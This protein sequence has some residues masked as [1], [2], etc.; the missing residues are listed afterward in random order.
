MRGLISLTS[1]DEMQKEID[2]LKH[3]LSK[4]E[5]HHKQANNLENNM[6][7]LSDFCQLLM[8]DIDVLTKRIKKLGE[9]NSVPARL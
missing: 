1:M 3:R 6:I 5:E 9:N 4:L 8:D 7:S 2:E